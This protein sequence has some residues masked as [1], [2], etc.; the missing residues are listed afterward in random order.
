MVGGYGIYNPGADAL[1]SDSAG[2]GNLGLDGV[3]W[4]VEVVLHRLGVWDKMAGVLVGVA[5]LI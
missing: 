3:F 1:G 4:F 5:A 2:G